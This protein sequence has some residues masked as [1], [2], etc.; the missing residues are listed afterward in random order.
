MGASKQ[1]TTS[2]PEPSALLGHGHIC[3]R[4]ALQIKSPLETLEKAEIN[5]YHSHHG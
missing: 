4:T 1:A 2:A 5:A 3:Y